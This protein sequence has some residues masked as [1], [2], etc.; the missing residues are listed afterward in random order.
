MMVEEMEKRTRRI[1]VVDDEQNVRLTMVEALEPLGFDVQVAAS[2]EEAMSA[3]LDPRVELVLLDLKMPGVD[4]LEVLELIER[5]RPGL[6]VVII[7]AHGTVDSAVASMKHGARDLI[8]K[9]F[10]LEQIRDVVRT[11]MDIEVR[12]TETAS[13]Y[14]AHL[15]RAR[16]LIRERGFQAAQEHV[17]KAL[18]ENERGAEAFNLA[19]VLAL[20]RA[21]RPAAQRQWRLALA[22]DPA[23]GPAKRNLARSMRWLQESGPPDLGDAEAR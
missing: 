12:S 17:A 15:S 7:T 2:G 8:Q 22:H 20:L 1:L 3:V 6:R 21:D 16:T 11:E 13:R 18:A 5:E 10:S 23:Y 19:G 4:G 14:E 9:P